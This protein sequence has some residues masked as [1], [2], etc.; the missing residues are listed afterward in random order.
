MAMVSMAARD[1]LRV[2]SVSICSLSAR[3]GAVRN[4]QRSS[5]WIK[6]VAKRGEVWTIDPVFT[7]TAR[8]STRHIAAYPGKDYAILAWLTREIIDGG[9]L[10]PKQPINGLEEL[11]AAGLLDARSAISTLGAR[12][13]S[14]MAPPEDTGEGEE[15]EDTESADPAST[16]DFDSMVAAAEAAVEDEDEGEEEKPR[17]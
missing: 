10:D 4:A 13:M 5:I 14:N 17:E 16:H 7:H 9:P 11:R 12:A 2:T 3:S 6:A 15:G 1:S 8:F